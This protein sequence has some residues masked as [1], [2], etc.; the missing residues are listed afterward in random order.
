MG[1]IISTY[2]RSKSTV[3]ATV[4]Y[5]SL[6]RIIYTKTFIPTQVFYKGTYIMVLLV[7]GKDISY[8]VRSFLEK[9]LFREKGFFRR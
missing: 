3:L 8:R 7:F 6:Y 4:L 5:S 9:G 2:R 1:F